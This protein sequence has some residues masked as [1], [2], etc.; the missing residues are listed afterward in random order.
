MVDALGRK[1][2]N[3]V[4]PRRSPTRSNTPLVCESVSGKW[5]HRERDGASISIRSASCP[6]N[7]NLNA[8]ERSMCSRLI[9]FF[10]VARQ[11]TWTGKAPVLR[12][13]AISARTRM[14]QY[15][16]SDGS[17]VGLGLTYS[18]S[19]VFVV[20][21]VLTRFAWWNMYLSLRFQHNTQFKCKKIR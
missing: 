6:G 2:R 10:R 14:Y 4:D 3:K 9:G 17:F 7:L 19:V 13:L 12:Y 15:S 18:G 1:S 16:R 21:V 11:H 5:M 20:Q 8:N